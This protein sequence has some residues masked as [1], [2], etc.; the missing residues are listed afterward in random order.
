MYSLS[1]VLL[2]TWMHDRYIIN[3]SEHISLSIFL[4]LLKERKSFIR[5]LFGKYKKMPFSFKNRENRNK[6]DIKCGEKQ[7]VSDPITKAKHWKAPG[8]NVN[9]KISLFT[10][11]KN[12]CG[13]CWTLW[14]ISS[15]CKLRAHSTDIYEW[16]FQHPSN[17]LEISYNIV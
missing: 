4:Q 1:V 8:R 13:L 14:N 10:T 12:V 17:S 15:A 6:T 16:S 5:W 2:Y 7:F 3:H 9:M 11:K